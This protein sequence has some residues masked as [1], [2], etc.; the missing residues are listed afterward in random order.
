MSAVL[1]KLREYETVFVVNPELADDA[2]SKL[3]ERLKG[4]LAKQKAE[5][6]HE[7]SWGKRKLSFEVKKHIRGNYIQY[8]YVGTPG[9]VE[10]LERAMRNMDTV[11][12][13]LT[14]MNG[15]VVDV[16]AKRAE[17]E[18]RVRERAASK[19]KAEAERKE[20]E[21]RRE[22]EAK[23]SAQEEHHESSSSSADEAARVES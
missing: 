9:V 6:L 17:V 23:A 3:G 5:L 21:E 11:L 4:V 10:E 13:F 20:R 7:E 2:V 22:A 18:K 15:E 8:H 19:A 16:E 14:T 12:R 1:G